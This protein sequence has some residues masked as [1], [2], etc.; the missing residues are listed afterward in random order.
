MIA[1]GNLGNCFERMGDFERAAEWYR[2]GL[3]LFER[4]RGLQRDL[5]RVYRKLN[6]P[7]FALSMAEE[8][9]TKDTPRYCL[10]A[11]EIYAQTGE[12]DKAFALYTRAMELQGS[13]LKAEALTHCGDLMH[14]C[15]K[16]PKKALEYYKQALEL[17][18]KRMRPTCISAG[19]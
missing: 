16:K 13:L 3:A 15:R 14:Y 6:R 2:R 10:E 18:G 4:S 5:I 17:T 8:C 1:Y 19:M 9:Y 7:F 11:G 12:Y